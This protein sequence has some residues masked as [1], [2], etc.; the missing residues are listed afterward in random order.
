[1]TNSEQTSNAARFGE[2]L[3]GQWRRYVGFEKCATDWLIDK[4]LPRALV[5]CL[6]WAFLTSLL[7]AI[8]VL[9]FGVILIFAFIFIAAKCSKRVR[10]MPKE[11]SFGKEDDHRKSVFYDPINYNDADDPRFDDN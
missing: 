11:S 3:A 2:W 4:G 7:I 6:K 10:P 9:S 1:M 8:C 5:L